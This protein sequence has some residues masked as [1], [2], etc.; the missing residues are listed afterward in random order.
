MRKMRTLLAAAAAIA[1]LFVLPASA[2]AVPPQ[3][4][5]VEFDLPGSNDVG[6]EGFCPFP[7]Q[8][9]A[10]TKQASPAPEGPAVQHFTGFV[11][12][13]VTNAETGESLTFNAS[14]PQTV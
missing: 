8:V 13:T 6:D 2:Q 1:G 11:S 10:G 5:T 3:A 7:V 4:E 9:G 12:V 14:G